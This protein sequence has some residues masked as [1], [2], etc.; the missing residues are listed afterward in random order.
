MA[1]L[2][3]EA[4]AQSSPQFSPRC[5]P[6]VLHLNGLHR[7][8]VRS[9][10]SIRDKPARCHAHSVPIADR[11]HGALLRALHGVWCSLDFARAPTDVLVAV[12]LQGIT[13]TRGVAVKS[14]ASMASLLA[15]RNP[16]RSRITEALRLREL[17]WIASAFVFLDWHSTFLPI[18][19]ATS[20]VPSS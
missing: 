19:R 12:S 8:R 16:P 14:C 13:S 17:M 15:G 11:R 4:L 6:K 3:Q 7:A 9:Y 5:K 10:S 1:K 20:P 2:D 18:C